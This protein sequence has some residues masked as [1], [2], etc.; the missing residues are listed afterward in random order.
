MKKILFFTPGLDIG[1][2]EKVFVTYANYLVEHN[3]LVYYA[4]CHNSGKLE[5]TL[6]TKV[7]R[8]SLGNIRLLYSLPLLI[9]LLKR[10]KPNYL[11]TG[12]DYSN[13]LAVIA[14]SFVKSTKCILSHH[15]Y[16]NIETN[17]TISTFLMRMFYNR[18]HK[19]ISVS[20][21]ISEFLLSIGIKST[22]LVTIYN[23]LDIQQIKRDCMQAISLKLNLPYN[24]YLVFVGRLSPVKNLKMMFD[25]FKLVLFKKSNIKLV[26]VGDGTEYNTLVEYSHLL[27]INK[28]II[29]IGATSNPY[30]YMKYA[31]LVLLSSL[32]E[33]LPTVIL[34]S[35]VLG[36]TVVSTPTEGA[37]DLLANGKFGYLSPNVDSPDLFA[38]AILTAYDSKIPSEVLYERAKMFSIEKQ[39]NA[40][41]QILV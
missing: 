25:A 5:K 11:I 19:I 1:G 37:K 30:L 40:L 27:G 10:I 2:I 35:F 39:A 24:D 38:D 26:I 31:Q 20:K 12:G 22:Q 6:S 14:T 33:A 16:F 41:C 15:S 28:S 29:F 4:Y 8:C 7:I 32:S 3:Y 13:C 36:K 21:G 34:E 18:S 23:P 9:S 17:K